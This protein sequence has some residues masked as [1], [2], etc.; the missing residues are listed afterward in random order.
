MTIEESTKHERLHALDALRAIAMML[1]VWLHAAMPY[2]EGLPPF[3]WAVTDPEKSTPISLSVMFIHSWRM[4]VFFMLSGFFTAMLVLRRGAMPT[5]VHRAKRLLIPFVLAMLILQPL[6]AAAWGFGYSS[7]WGWPTQESITNMIKTAWGVDTFGDNGQFGLLW[8]FWFLYVLCYFVAAGLLA[9]GLVHA[10][11][12]FGGRVYARVVDRLGA[13]IAWCVGSWFGV[14]LLAIPVF[15][16]LYTQPI[17]SPSALTSLKPQWEVFA[18]F[19]LPFVA[20]WL[21]YPHRSVIDRLAKRW[22]VAMTIGLALAV[23]L[24][25]SGVT[26]LDG[27][28]ALQ[29]EVASDGLIARI[30]IGHALMTTGFGLGLTGLFV[31][32]LSSPGPRLARVIRYGS[33]SSYWVYLV[34]LPMVVV[35]SVLAH[36]MGAPPE[37][38][39]LV[40]MVGSSVVLFVSYQFLVRYTPIGTLL[41]GKRTRRAKAD[42]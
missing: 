17:H 15:G 28:D 23:P 35:G 13:C 32:L 16:L 6:C 10:L 40:V 14:F 38:K 41:N 29:G 42:S 37:I 27:L 5:L 2:T 7:Q 20:G 24:Y 8:H 22:W 1:G 11:G 31:Q 4:E 39:M 33:D 18:Y 12:R 26:K 3:F 34:H 19:A 25:L 36:K 21:L 9:H 30:R